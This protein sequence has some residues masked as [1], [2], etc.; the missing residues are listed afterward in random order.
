MASDRFDSMPNDQKADLL[1]RLK[2]FL[3]D[4][5]ACLYHWQK[6]TDDCAD[7]RVLKNDVAPFIAGINSFLKELG[8]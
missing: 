4:S 6:T 8:I 7:C 3:V 5:K 2:S 1:R